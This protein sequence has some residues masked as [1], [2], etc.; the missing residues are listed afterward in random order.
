MTDP[1]WATKEARRVLRALGFE[2]TR[3]QERELAEYLVAVLDE[4]QRIRDE[5]TGP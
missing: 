3:K 5:S 2:A 1:S 4:Q